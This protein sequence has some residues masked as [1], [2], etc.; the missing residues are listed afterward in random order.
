MSE[1]MSNRLEWIQNRTRDGY[2]WGPFVENLSK[3]IIYGGEDGHGLVVDVSEIADPHAP[4]RWHLEPGPNG[5]W[6]HGPSG[7]S[8]PLIECLCSIVLVSTPE[9]TNE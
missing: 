6:S 2:Q 3:L 4:Q 7:T 5:W 9:V 8:G 1:T